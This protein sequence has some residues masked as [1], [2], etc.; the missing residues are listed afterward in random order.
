M[1]SNQVNIPGLMTTWQKKDLSIWCYSLCKQSRY[2]P[3]FSQSWDFI[4]DFH[5]CRDLTSLVFIFLD[6]TRHRLAMKLASCW[7]S[8]FITSFWRLSAWYVST[9]QHGT[10][11]CGRVTPGE[12]CVGYQWVFKILG[13]RNSYEKIVPYGHFGKFVLWVGL[14]DSMFHAFHA[15]PRILLTR[16]TRSRS[17][18]C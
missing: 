4:P 18:R 9:L 17:G 2:P 10:H 16:P 5:G 8:L 3:S 15:F 1:P 14:H 13:S 11:A 12:C 7:Q 6:D